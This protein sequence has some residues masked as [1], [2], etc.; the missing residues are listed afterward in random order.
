MNIF[1]DIYSYLLIF[2]IFTRKVAFGEVS[3]HWALTDLFCHATKF[4]SLYA[5]IMIILTGEQNT[6]L[7]I[8]FG[9]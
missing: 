7:L 4:L 3:C 1:T 2:I 8:F 5:G 9:H 6:T